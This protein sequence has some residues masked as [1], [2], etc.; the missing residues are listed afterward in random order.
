MQKHLIKFSTI[1]NVRV[2]TDICYIVARVSATVTMERNVEVTCYT[3]EQVTCYTYEQ[4]TCYTYEHIILRA[5][6][7]FIRFHFYGVLYRVGRHY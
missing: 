7:F 2:F 6:F 5:H 4:V 1:S 3:Y